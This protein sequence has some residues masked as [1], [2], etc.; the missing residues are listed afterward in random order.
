MKRSIL[1]MLT[2]MLIISSIWGTDFD[3]E[4]KEKIQKILTFE[5]STKPGK[6]QVDNI[7][8]A[9]SVF[10]YNGKDVQLLIHKTIKAEDQKALQ[11]AIEEVAL[12]ITPAGNTIDLYVDGPF[13]CKEDEKQHCQW[14]DPGYKVHYDFEIKVPHK[15]SLLLKTVT[16]GD[17]EVNEIE[18]AF[19]IHNV[20]GQITIQEIAGAGTAH[21]V[22]GRIKVIF[23][24]NPQSNCSFKTMNGDLDVFFRENLSAEFRL[25]TFTGDIYSDFP[26]KYLPSRPAK[27][28][29]NKGKFVYK[30]DSFVGVQTGNG[31]P[32][33]KMDTFNGDILIK[34]RSLN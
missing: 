19:D 6:I 14:D 16:E 12:N 1:F 7:F 8:G 18:G 34:K 27:A 23:S 33:L 11:R 32:E 29:R 22:N 20:N 3:I 9:I 5:D 2:A 30:S 25:K 31:G 13:R 15:T 17:I 21:T 4:K 24:H 26:V 28:E 10:G